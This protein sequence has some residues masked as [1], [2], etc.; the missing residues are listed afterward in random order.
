[1]MAGSKA[2]TAWGGM[3]SGQNGGRSGAG[4][5]RR[6]GQAFGVSDPKPFGVLILVQVPIFTAF[7]ALP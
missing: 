3:L 6:A 5:M 7:H 2:R 4:V 1:M